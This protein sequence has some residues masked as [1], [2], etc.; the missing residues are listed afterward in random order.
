[1]E[2]ADRDRPQAQAAFKAPRVPVVTRC[3][4]TLGRAAPEGRGHRLRAAGAEA[5][6]W[7]PERRAVRVWA[8]RVDGREQVASRVQEV[9]EGRS[10]A[11]QADLA[12]RVLVVRRDG[13]ARPEVE[14]AVSPE[15]AV[16]GAPVEFRAQVV[17]PARAECRVQAASPARAAR[18]TM[19][20]RDDNKGP[21][22]GN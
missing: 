21:G 4:R 22:G 7:L 14:P 16:R 10:G 9:W 6:A 1:M 15:Q 8:R 20:S 2:V 11:V 5:A 3:L 12:L 19:A 13:A 18:A 17:Y